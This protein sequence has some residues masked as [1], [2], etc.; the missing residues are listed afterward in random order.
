M[1][2]I[3]RLLVVSVICIAGIIG[4]VLSKFKKDN[5][6]NPNYHLKRINES[7]CK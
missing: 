1:K 2:R 6:S 7:K 3:I 5:T 4:W